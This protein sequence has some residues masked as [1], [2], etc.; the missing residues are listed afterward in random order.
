MSTTENK[1]TLKGGVEKAD[2]PGFLGPKEQ[3]SGESPVFSFYLIYW[4]RSEE[5]RIQESQIRTDPKKKK[6][7]PAKNFF[8]FSFRTRKGLSNKTENFKTTIVLLQA[9]HHKKPVGPHSYP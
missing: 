4:F 8:F 7:A 6:K 1:K 2:C 5:A 3:H 9:K